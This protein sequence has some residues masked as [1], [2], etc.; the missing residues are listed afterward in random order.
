MSTVED[1]GGVTGPPVRSPARPRRWRGWLLLGS[2]GLLVAA[3]LAWYLWP[4]DA[5]P[6][7]PEIPW[8]EAEPAVAHILRKH[9]QA[10]RA[11]P[12][13]GQAWGRLG[14]VLL[15]NGYPTQAYDCLVRA[16]QL[17]PR[18]PNWPYLQALRLL[19]HDRASA[20][21]ALRRALAL[22]EKAGSAG[23]PAARLRLAEETLKD[24]DRK[25]AEANCR[26]VLQRDSENAR[27]HFL[28]GVLAFED[29][30]LKTSLEHLSRAT[31]SPTTRRRAYTQLVA[32]YRRLKDQATA[33]QLSRRLRELPADLPLEDPII[34]QLS[35]L[36]R[37][38]Q[39]QFQQAERLGKQ[40]RF[41]EQAKL[42]RD[43]AG[44]FPDA[45]SHELLGM[46][47]AESGDLQTAEAV[48]RGAAREDPNL[49]RTHYFLGMVLLQ[50]GE[51]LR[52]EPGRKDAA[53]EKFRQAAESARR[54]IRL[55]ENHGSSHWVLGLALQRLG[56]R[57]EAIAAFRR[58]IQ[59]R[60]DYAGF[61]LY[62]GEALAEDGQREAAITALEQAAELAPAGDTRARQALE[63]LR[64]LKG[65]GP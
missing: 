37:T 47:L 15:A 46:A 12:R 51:N 65:K 43:L 45:R 29:N 49:A 39:G 13:S 61:H 48:L 14:M 33:D 36:E 7:P 56:Q 35:H 27:A 10:V 53:A 54:A 23:I 9:Y 20:V 59:R 3:G 8:E 57:S 31:R 1:K 11:E 16:E 64:A 50:Q 40:G 60:P 26:L 41:G 2:A 42:M 6:A 52:Q 30:N 4:R 34:E 32:V 55:Y 63:R 38:R 19:V 24:G 62:L 17:D 58:A 44:E 5:G 25:E 22:W 28:L 18:E 21:A